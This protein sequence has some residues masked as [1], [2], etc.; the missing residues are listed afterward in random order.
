M[1][2]ISSA[3]IRG[4][5]SYPKCIELMRNAAEMVSNGNSVMPLRHAMSLPESRN[6]LGIMPGYLAGDTQSSGVKLLSLYPD[7]AAAGFPSHMGL[8]ILFDA[9]FGQ[10]VALMDANAL[11][12]IRTASATAAA[13]DIL[14]RKDARVMLII[15]TGEQA[16]SHIRALSAIRAF[17]E[18]RIWGRDHQKA[19]ALAERLQSEISASLNPFESLEKAVVGS[20]IITTVT[21]SPTPI[22]GADH[23]Q[24]GV[25]I[26][27]VGAS[28]RGV[29]EIAPKILAN[30]RLFV[31]HLPSALDQA[32]EMI[33]ALKQGYLSSVEEV[34]EIGDVFLKLKAGRINAQDIT[35][36]KSLGIAAQDIVAANFIA[37]E[38]SRLG[39]GQVL[40]L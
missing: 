2:F 39:L 18:I 3:E 36:Y 28:H 23:I 19:G 10:P 25:H 5:L 15:G 22:L 38:A 20:D 26:N 32:G 37:K 27:A 12:A 13:T 29:L 6:K 8:Y 7:N 34:F 33:A 30:G 4:I 11:T 14:A 1:R 17:D 40:S 31:D 16:E 24:P 35:V 21:G 9:E